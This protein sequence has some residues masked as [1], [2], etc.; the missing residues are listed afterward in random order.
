MLCLDQ[1]VVENRIVGQP[2]RKIY[3]MVLKGPAAQK[4]QP[5]QFLHLKVSGGRDPLLRR[6]V[7]IAGIDRQKEQVTLY[8]QVRGKGT[9]LL[10]EIRK[11]QY[12]NILGPL[13]T[14]FTIPKEGNLLL[15][16][17]GIGIF[18]LYSLLQ[19]VDSAKVNIR[20][21]WGA[22]SRD[23]LASADLK[24]LQAQKVQTELA[25]MDGSLGYKG[26]VTDLFAD[27]CGNPTTWASSSPLRSAACDTPIVRVAACGP[28]GMLKTVAEICRRQDIPLEVSLEE[29]MACGVGACLGCVCTV[30]KENGELGRKRVCK[31]GPVFN[32]KEVVWD[33]EC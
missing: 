5:G 33:E 12:V 18:P 6:P 23:T 1:R 32:S 20:F 26:P 22:E 27:A 29:R 30:R 11:G 25:T 17:G 10:T 8:Y 14:G 28:V 2:A 19:A 21:F 15:I 4:A 31:E 9:G 13:G 7:S 16:A 3:K 24:Y